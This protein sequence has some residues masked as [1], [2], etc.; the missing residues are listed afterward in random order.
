MRFSKET[1]VVCVRRIR[2]DDGSC[3]MLVYMEV[4]APYATHTQT[5]CVQKTK[6]T[7][8]FVYLKKPHHQ[9]K[10]YYRVLLR[11]LRIVAVIGC[12]E[13]E[14]EQLYTEHPTSIMLRP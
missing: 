7:H 3:V 5:K 11:A 4:V 9:H 1:S 12:G 6:E 14:G 13:G 8:F 2:A 10:T